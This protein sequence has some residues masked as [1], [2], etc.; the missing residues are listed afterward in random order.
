VP[1]ATADTIG[2]YV[3]ELLERV[4]RT[5]DKVSDSQL[6]FKVIK[7]AGRRVDTLKIERV[8]VEE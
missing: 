7:M 8:E 1:D 3:M 4:P 2:G 5:G 6:S